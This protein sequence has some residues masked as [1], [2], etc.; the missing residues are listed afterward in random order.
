VLVYTW[1]GEV[2][3]LRRRSPANFWQSVTGSL[4]W[5]ESARLAAV[6]E[7]F[8][9]TGLRAGGALQDCHHRVRFPIVGSW[10]TRYAPTVRENTEHW[11][12][13]CLSSRRH[14]RLNHVEHSEYRWVPAGRAA[15]LASSWTNR[16]AILRLQSQAG[17]QFVGF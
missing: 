10:R 5:G 1:A 16:D 8:E 2:L 15:A 14:I 4:R 13:L 3:M 6:R 9:E 7:L 11:F 17:M 12:R